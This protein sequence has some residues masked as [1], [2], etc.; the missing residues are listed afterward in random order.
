M[1][2]RRTGTQNVPEMKSRLN[3]PGAAR[4]LPGDEIIIKQMEDYIYLECLLESN[5][6]QMEG[7]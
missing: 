5:R 3:K 2:T 1:K 4:R 6:K 7:V